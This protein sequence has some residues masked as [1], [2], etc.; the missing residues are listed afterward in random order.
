MANTVT[1]RISAEDN[2]SGTLDKYNQGVNTAARNTRDLEEVSKGSEGAL[3]R[4]NSAL[5]IGASIFAAMK[6]ADFVADIVNMGREA[7]TTESVFRQLT[8]SADG[9]QATLEALRTATSGIVDDMTLMRGANQLM[10]MGLA[11]NSEELA[12]L[13]EMAVKLGGALGMD[14]TKAVSDFGLML[15]NQSIMRLDQFGISGAKVRDE[16][17]RLIDTGRAASREEAFKLAVMDI[18]SQALERLGASADAA[19]GPLARLETRVANL[20]QDFAGNVATSVE[21]LIGLGEIALGVNP[22]QIANQEKMDAEAKAFADEYMTTLQEYLQM[23][24]MDMEN[25]AAGDTAFLSEF[26]QAAFVEAQNNPNLDM[27]QL[28]ERILSKNPMEMVDAGKYTKAIVAVFDLSEA[29]GEIAASN[30]ELATLTAER[31]ALVDNMA[32]ELAGVAGMTEA[33][34][35]AFGEAVRKQSEAIQGQR[36]YLAAIAGL[37]GG[38]QSAA[39]TAFQYQ[40]GAM[41]A[42]TLSAMQ[43]GET[44]QAFQM[45]E[46]MTG[47]QAAAIREQFN[48]AQMEVQRLQEMAAA[49]L[50]QDADVERARGL[51][52]NLGVMADD[53]DR[54][55]AAFENMR[56]AD[57]LGTG[58][59]GIRGELTDRLMA[60]M[61][62][63]GQMAP[64]QLAALR[65]QLDLQSGRIT[66]A[67]LALD[68][69]VMPM[70]QKIAESQGTEAA[71]RAMENLAASMEQAKL[72]GAGE[73]G[74]AA[75]MGI[76]TGFGAGGQAMPFDPALAGGIAAAGGP[77]GVLQNFMGGMAGMMGGTTGPEGEAAGPVGGLMGFFDKLM[78]GGEGEGAAAA[79]PQISEGLNTVN[80]SVMS[81]DETAASA[82]EKFAAMKTEVDGGLQALTEMEGV[83]GNIAGDYEVKVRVNV[84]AVG[85]TAVLSLLN[86]GA[87]LAQ[88]VRDN[89]GT[90][91]GRQ[92]R[93]IER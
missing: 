72:R 84:E 31:A 48:Q 43:A 17:Q 15:A 53:A 3:N 51:A 13:T 41:D 66:E 1:I 92:A 2:F 71:A 34:A 19:A 57:V 24:G 90:V 35:M 38:L 12:T 60:S 42:G 59:G 40:P 69:Q 86:G 68:Q 26:L 21:G 79:L 65:E 37:Q 46:F 39:A 73:E 55:A 75:T 25:T 32:A 77:M 63:S 23:A 45:P 61:G 54:A 27:A 4:L 74:I 11:T 62:E 82:A 70:I 67:S 7:N 56:L 8:S 50:I 89:G 58:G 64:E 14:A 88:A 9:Y 80:E 44:G 36:E 5:Q 81:V 18:G 20:A 85:N 76:F 47:E 16:I 83:L 52:T 78:G 30:A 93:V 29:E 10:Q 33:D 87:G 28:V 22:I 6:A 91:P 49:G